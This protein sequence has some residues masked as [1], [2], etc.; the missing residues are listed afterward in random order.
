MCG[1]C[2]KVVII[3]DE[4]LISQCLLSYLTHTEN[5]NVAIQS[6]CLYIAVHKFLC[7][8]ADS[9]HIDRCK[10]FPVYVAVPVQTRWFDWHM[11]AVIATKPG[12]LYRF[13][14]LSAV[15]SSS[16][17]GQ[18]I[19]SGVWIHKFLYCATDFDETPVS[20]TSVYSKS[21]TARLE[22]FHLVLCP[23]DHVMT[24]FSI[25]TFLCSSR[26]SHLTSATT[27]TEWTPTAFFLYSQWPLQ[28]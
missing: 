14:N 6:C 19:S 24:F 3:G 23:P 9:H 8:V 15:N 7:V 28:L 4:E 27:A 11:A 26:P 13:S 5:A 2:K 21:I 25:G 16:I 22:C 12:N 10:S 1:V 17:A 20:W 18:Q